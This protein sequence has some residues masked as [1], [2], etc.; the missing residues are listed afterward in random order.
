MA[1]EKE[2]GNGG[3]NKTMKKMELN[4]EAM[5]NSCGGKVWSVSG[6]N[7]LKVGKQLSEK[8]TK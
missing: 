7:G 1:K 5:S 4:K 2:D 8:D 3:L 6:N